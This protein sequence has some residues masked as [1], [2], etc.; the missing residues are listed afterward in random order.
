[1]TAKV[2]IAP[3]NIWGNSVA[4]GSLRKCQ[5]AV[6]ALAHVQMNAGF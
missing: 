6:F 4:L 1:M 2:L 5:L 3:Q